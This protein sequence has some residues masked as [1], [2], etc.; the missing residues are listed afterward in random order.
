MAECSMVATDE[1][2][3]VLCWIGRIGRGHRLGGHWY[4]ESVGLGGPFSKDTHR[5]R[6]TSWHIRPSE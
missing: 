3:D 2:V 4:Q 1:Q 6:R 5:V